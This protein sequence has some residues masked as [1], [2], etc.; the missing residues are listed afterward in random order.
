MKCVKYVCL[1][2]YPYHKPFDLSYFLSFHLSS[3]PTFILVY[4]VAIL[5]R[6]NF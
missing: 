6:K 2:M 1:K 4:Q 5:Q 3:P